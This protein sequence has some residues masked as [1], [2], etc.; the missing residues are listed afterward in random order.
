MVRVNYAQGKRQ[1]ETAKKQ[2]REEKL[3]RKAERK[4]VESTEVDLQNTEE[5]APDSPADAEP[6]P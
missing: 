5:G 3:L 1:R 6:E 4:Q 2:K